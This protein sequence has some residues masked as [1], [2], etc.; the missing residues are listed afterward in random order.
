[1]IPEEFQGLENGLV[2][3]LQSDIDS[4]GKVEYTFRSDPLRASREASQG[5]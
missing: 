3:A 4:Q 2:L 5:K 1:M